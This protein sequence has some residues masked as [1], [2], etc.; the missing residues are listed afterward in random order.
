M[1]VCVCHCVGV[2]GGTSTRPSFISAITKR[3][4]QPSLSQLTHRSQSSSP[5]RFAVCVNASM[6]IRQPYRKQY[7]RSRIKGSI[8]R[9]SIVVSS[10]LLWQSS[11]FLQSSFHRPSGR[12]TALYG[13]PI[14]LSSLTVKELREHVKAKSNERGLLSKLKR[15]QDLI[16]FLE[17]NSVE[18]QT[19]VSKTR[20]RPLRMPSTEVTRTL[21]P[22]DAIFERVFKRYPPVRDLPLTSNV[23]TDVRQ[24]YHPMLQNSNV[25]S[26]MDVVFIGTA[27]CTPSV[28]RGVSCTALRLN[29]RRRALF[30]D[31]VTN[32]MHQMESS[33]QGGTWLFDAGEC[34]QV[35]LI[36]VCT[37]INQRK[38]NL[39]RKNHEMLAPV[40]DATCSRRSM[41]I[42]IS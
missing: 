30:V 16:D 38:M 17:A 42:F 29:W 18:E 23:T 27:S 8:G 41:A 25:S 11:A 13:S 20:Q 6:R 14:P 5:F 33:F 24:I 34:T 7:N 28:T 26:D 22:K 32:R 3:S 2:N 19:K 12:S 4:D 1:S 36:I 15:K 9:I 40:R 31:P 35:C 21:S 10:L 39:H 37:A